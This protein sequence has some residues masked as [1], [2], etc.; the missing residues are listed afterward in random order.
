ML[1]DDTKTTIFITALFI[2][3]QTWNDIFIKNEMALFL[4]GCLRRDRHREQPSPYGDPEVHDQMTTSANGHQCPSP[5]E[6]NSTQDRK[7]E[8]LEKLAKM[9]KA[10]PVVIFVRSQNPFW[11][12]LQHDLQFLG[13]CK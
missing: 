8:I 7:T 2:T 3:A 5:W 4:P 9:Y 10:T 12:W 1:K 13:L 6:G 11:W